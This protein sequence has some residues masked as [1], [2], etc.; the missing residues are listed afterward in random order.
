MSLDIRAKCPYNNAASEICVSSTCYRLNPFICSNICKDSQCYSNHRGCKFMGW[1]TC[2]KKLTVV[3]FD[4][5]EA[6]KEF[7]AE[8]D[9]IYGRLVEMVES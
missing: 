9:E 3:A 1:G 8:V 2:K 4:K 7:V 6:F 5:G